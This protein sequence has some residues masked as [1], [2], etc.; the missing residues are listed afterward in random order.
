MDLLSVLPDFHTKP[1]AHILPPLE[2][3][4]ITT[5][6]LITLDTLEIAKRAHV[7]PAD[8]RRL[9]A[10][11]IKALHHDIG[12]EDIDQPASAEPSSSINDDL[13]ITLG[14]T[15]K[16]DL[17]QWSAISTLD[18]ALDELLGG[19]VPTSYVTEVTGESGSGKTQFLLTLLLAVQLPSPRGLGKNAVYISTEAPLSTPRL[20]QLVS[21]HPYLSTLPRDRAPT[22]ENILSIN[23]MDLESQDHILNYQ[24][25]V[26]IQR[27]NIGL[28]VIDSI[29][30]NYR[31]EH[32]AHNMLG[33]S[34]RS[35][36]LTKL[37]QMLRNLAVQEDI[38]IVVANQ[39]SDRFDAM[40]GPSGFPKIG[41]FV[42]GNG[43]PSTQ[44]QQLQS[45]REPGTASPLPRVR[46][47]ESGNVELSQ[48]NAMPPSSPSP[49]PSSPY[50]AEEDPQQQPFDGSYLVGN[51]VRSEILSLLHQQR[52]FT[53]WGDSP[54]SF[55]PSSFPGFQR[56]SQKTPALGL[57]WSTQ[58]AC[59]IALK[60]ERQ[61][62]I[63][64]LLPES[65]P[66][67]STAK[68]HPEPEAPDS[69]AEREQPQSDPPAETVAEEKD[70]EEKDA[71]AEASPETV[72]VPVPAPVSENKP[73]SSQLPPSSPQPPERPVRRT[74]KLVFAPWTGGSVNEQNETQDEVSFTIWK[75]GL[76]SCE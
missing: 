41:G 68:V 56:P 26:A 50:A 2:R 48:H 35:G 34:T 9:C 5:V 19:G 18:T 47:T 33:L 76:K 40:D 3:S 15:T 12:F 73:S 6:D 72:S 59:R 32:T 43:S 20:S 16:L 38:A 65:T 75:G 28:V 67:P 52:F 62:A 66:A 44:P 42:P 37:G 71:E 74:M 30:S 51:P 58:I 49:F 13:P 25:P 7:P 55:P 4:K 22:L 11:V 53:G 21:S 29:T 60:K 46:A 8:V 61:T 1:Y 10:S 57:V 24:L 14:P 45:A 64:P 70:A 31:A 54:Q 69:P 17:S 39:V 63:D 36:E 23:A 27:Y